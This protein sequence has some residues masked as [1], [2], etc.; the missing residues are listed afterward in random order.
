MKVTTISRDYGLSYQQLGG[1]ALGVG[2]A[3]RLMSTTMEIRMEGR[4]VC[5]KFYWTI[6][7]GL[8][9][10]TCKPFNLTHQNGQERRPC[11]CTE[12][13]LKIGFTQKPYVRVRSVS[14][15]VRDVSPSV[16][17]AGRLGW[18][19]LKLVARL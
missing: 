9:L 16:A 11:R 8:K 14:C 2:P 10:A 18:Q 5:T 17:L 6:E 7:F 15:S 3:V 1:H 19:F 4:S 12:I 13:V